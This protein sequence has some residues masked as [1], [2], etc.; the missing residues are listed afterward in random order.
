MNSPKYIFQLTKKNNILSFDKNTMIN[1]ENKIKWNEIHITQFIIHPFFKNDIIEGS[2]M[3]YTS[4]SIDIEN[5]NENINGRKNYTFQLL[6]VS[7]KYIYNGLYSSKIINN[8]NFIENN[9]KI[10]LKLNIIINDE[11][12]TSDFYNDEND[13]FD[14]ATICEI[15]LFFK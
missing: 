9:E 4:L 1:S 11:F 10:E 7:T 8:T 12:N 6:D 13:E 15:E 5:F 3:C 2:N 14:D